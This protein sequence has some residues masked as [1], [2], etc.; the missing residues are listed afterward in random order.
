MTVGEP[1][2]DDEDEELRDGVE[3]EIEVADIA[4]Q[5]GKSV[6]AVSARLGQLGLS[7]PEAS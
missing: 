3:A 6:S 4:A 2:T 5:M 1:W 7:A